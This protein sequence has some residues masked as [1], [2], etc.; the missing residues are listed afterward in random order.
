MA[1]RK[2]TNL[3][4]SIFQT[5]A[6]EKYLNAT[7]DQLISEPNNTQLNQFIG[8]KTGGSFQKNDSYVTESTSQRQNYQLEPSV[9]YKDSSGNVKDVHTVDD[10][11]NSL[12]YN[13]AST[14][15]QSLLFA[16]QYYNYEGW[17]DTDKL[18][19]Y[20]EYFWLPQGPDVV[21]VGGN[22]V[23]NKKTFTVNRTSLDSF[24]NYYTFDRNTDIN[25]VIYLARGGEYTFNVNQVSAQIGFDTVD[26]DSSGY[27]ANTET[28]VAEIP[29]Y[30]QTEIGTSGVSS[31]QSNIS[32]REV[33]GVVNNG[34]GT[35]SIIFRVPELSDIDFYQN[36]PIVEQNVNFATELSYT[37]IHNKLKSQIDSE[38]N[39]IDG[40]LNYVGKTLVFANSSADERNWEAGGIF[41]GNAGFDSEVFDPT[42]VLSFAERYSI[43]RIDVVDSGTDQLIQLTQIKNIPEF[44]RVSI[45]E[46]VTYARRQFYKNSQQYLELVPV[47]TST[48][49]TLYYQDGINPNMFGR[50]VL[51]DQGS[52]NIID[53][54]NDIIAQQDYTAPNGVVF[55]NGLK[56][57]FDSSV[58]P[59]E[60]Q[61]TVY[62]VEG[63]GKQGGICLV[64]ESK[65]IT[66]ESYS[67]DLSEP[68]DTVGFDSGNFDGTENSPTD[69]D[70]ILINR[71]SRDNNGW[72]RYNRWFHKKV[73]E[74]SATYNNF[75]LVIDQNARAKRP[76]L[77]FLP[78][79]QLFNFG[80][81]SK[82]PVSLFDTTQT[83]ALSN[84]AST[85]G[86]YSDNIQLASQMRIVFSAD[87]D[88]DVRR[89]VYRVDF[90]DQDSNESTGK[91]IDLVP[92]DTISEDDN[93]TVNFGFVNQGKTFYYKNSVWTEGQSKTKIMQEPLFDIF[94]GSH[95]SLSDTT[96][97]PSSDFAGSK[98]F[99]YKRNTVAAQDSVLG[100]GISYK[101]F[102]NIGDIVFENNFSTD[103]F[104]YTKTGATDPVNII[105]KSGHVHKH[106]YN[107]GTRSIH[108]GWRQ[109]KENSK[110][111]QVVTHIA[112]T[113]LYS[114]EIGVAPSL[115][116]FANI[117]VYVNNKFITS[118]LY[119]NTLINQK[120]YIV[121]VNPVKKDDNIVIKV[122]S[123]GQTSLGYYEVPINLENNANNEDFKDVT[124]GQIRNH[125]VE[126]IENIPNWSGNILGSNVSKD[127]DI[128]AYPGKILQHSAGNILSSYLLNN[129]ETNFFESLEYSKNEYTRFKN[130]FLDNVDKL[131]IDLQ[132]PI[133][134]V[135]KII[136]FMIGSKTNAF[137]FYYSDMLPWGDQKTTYNYVID[138][139]D[140]TF[141]EFG[142]QFDLTS[143]SQRGVLVYLT[144][145]NTTTQLLNGQ[146]Y[147]LDSQVA[148]I[149]LSTDLILNVNDTITIVEYTDTDGSF[150][151][152]TPTKLGLWPKY[153]PSIYLEDLVGYVD[154][155]TGPYKIYGTLDPDYAQLGKGSVGFVYPLYTDYNDAVTRDTQLGGEGKA[156]VHKFTGTNR[157]FYMPNSEAF[158]GAQDNTALNAYPGVR[159]VIRG[160]DGSKFVGEGD[161]R[162][163][164][165]L[166]LESR[167][168]NNIKTQYDSSLLDWST[169][170]TGFFRNTPT[171]R[172]V[173]LDI[174]RSSWGSWAE[175]NRVEQ[176][177]NTTFS[178]VNRF[179]WNHSQGA[180]KIE[181]QILPGGYRAI[182]NWLYDTDT[183]HL[184]PWEMLGLSEKPSWW[185]LRYGKPP[186]T[187]GNTVLWE[188]LRDGKLYT[189]GLGNTFTTIT[190][191]I[192]ADLME[193]I[194]VDSNGNLI[195]PSDF[196]GKDIFVSNANLDWKFGDWSPQETA[197]R[198]SSE[199]P[200]AVQLLGMLTAP[201]KYASLLWDTNLYEY[202]TDLQQI[203]Q[204]KRTYRPSLNAYNLH[205][206]QNNAGVVNRIEGYNQFI[207]NYL[208]YSNRSTVESQTRVQNLTLNLAYKVAGFTDKKFIK[209]AASNATPSTSNNNI[210]I[211]DEDINIAITKGTPLTKVFYSAVKIVKTENG[212]KLNG[213]DVKNP[214]FKIIPSV[215]ND[216]SKKF[217]IAS[218]NVFT[219]YNDYNRQIVSIPYGTV[220]STQQQVVDFLN[221]LQRYYNSQGIVFNTQE[222]GTPVDFLTGAKEFV[223]WAA[224]G[225][226]PGTVFS[227]S[228]G[229]QTLVVSRNQT[230]IDDLSNG[231]NLR[232][233]NGKPIRNEDYKVSRI[234]NTTTI[235]INTDNT[236]LASA[237]LDPI[238]YEHILVF[239]NTTIFNDLIYNPALGN[240]QERLKVIG[241]KTGNWNGTLHA[242]GFI[243][244]NDLF[245]IWQSNQN[246][247]RGDYVS[248]RN[249]LFVANQDHNGVEIFNY[250]FWDQLPNYKAGLL[251]NTA[252][253]SS[254]FENYFDI[255]KINLESNVDAAGKGII[256]FRKREWLENLGLDDVSQVKF[257]Q[258]MIRQKGTGQVIDKLI[259]ADLTNLNQEIS[260]YEEWGF[261]VGEYGSTDSNQVVEVTIDESNNKNNPVTLEFL[262]TSDSLQNPNN[263]KI[264]SS[265]LYRT[266]RG[267][268]KDIWKT[269][270][271]L[272]PVNDLNTV[273]YPRIDDVDHTIVDLD[274]D[275]EDF[276]ATV[277]SVMRGDKVWVARN[278]GTWDIFRV[279]ETLTNVIN[280]N[281]LT[282][283]F[284]ELTFDK[285]H[286]LVKDDVIIVKGN[287]IISGAYKVQEISASNTIIIKTDIPFIDGDLQDNPAPVYKFVSVRFTYLKDLSGYS[288]AF[289]F[290]INEFVWV[291][292]DNT[293]K[294][295][296]YQKKHV[297]DFADLKTSSVTDASAHLGN[298]VSISTTGNIAL[299]GAP[300]QNNGRVINYK[301]QNTKLTAAGVL[302]LTNS[303]IDGFGWAL[304]SGSDR[305]AIGAPNTN[306]NSGSVFVYT[307]N[308]DNDLQLAQVLCPN[309][310]ANR[311]Y[312]YSIA[313]S[314][315]QQYMV[316]GSPG[317]N[318]CYIY[319]LN[320][321]T[322]TTKTITG[323]GNT[324]YALGFTP[325]NAESILVQ[326]SG[327]VYIPNLDYTVT[328]SNI[329]FTSAVL[330][331]TDPIVTENTHY[332]QIATI[333]GSDTVAADRFGH[334]VDIDQNGRTII[335]GAPD[336]DVVDS[337]STLIANAGEVYIFSNTVEAFVANGTQTDFATTNPINTDPVIKIDIATSSDFA[338]AGQTVKFTTAPAKDSIVEVFTGTYKQTQ[339][340]DQNITGE[341]PTTGEQFGTSVS[342]DLDGIILAIGSPGEDET[343]PNTGS[344]FLYADSG[345]RVNIVQTRGTNNNYTSGDTYFVND[346]EITAS[347]SDTTLATFVADVN[348]ANI[349]GVSAQLDPTNSNRA[350][351]LG[352]NVRVRAGSGNTFSTGIGIQPYIKI[353]KINHPAGLE[354]ENF[355][356][357]V[358]F[359]KYIASDGTK[360]SNLV[361]SSSKNSTLIGVG[362]DIVADTTDPLY[363]TYK[364]TFDSDGTLFTDRIT[365]SGAA[366]TYQFVGSSNE[367]LT[368]LPQFIFEQK[369][370]NSKIN[371]LDE[372]GSSV[373][374]MN[375]TLLIGSKKD[376]E[377]KTNA[378][379]VYEFTSNGNLGWSKKRNETDKVDIKLFNNTMLYSKQSNEVLEF[380]DYID[381]YKLKVVGTAQQELNYLVDY[382]PAV[383]SVGSE[384]VNVNTNNPWNDEYVGKVWWDL[385]TALYLEYEQ[386]ELDYRTQNWGKLFPGATID[387]YEWIESSVPPSQYV[388]NGGEGTPKDINNFSVQTQY[389]TVNDSTT[390]KYYF[391]V[392]DK[393]TVPE[394]DF[395]RISTSA[396]ASLIQD[397]LSNGVKYLQFVD[398]NAVNI[399][400]IAN[401][402]NADNTVLSINYDRTSNDGVLHSQYELVSEGDASQ[403]LPDRI[404]N[405]LV[406]SISGQDSQGNTVPNPNLTPANKY[407]IEVRPRQTVYR[408]RFKALQVFVD[409]CNKIF[410]TFPVVRQANLS[411][412]LNTSES[413]P[414]S[415]SG[416]WDQK[417]LDNQE[418][419]FVNVAIINAGYKVL[420]ETD[421][422][423]NNRWSIYTLQTDKTWK[424]TRIQSYNTTESWDYVTWYSP[425][426]NDFTIPLYQ[427]NTESDLLTLVNATSGEIAKV[428]SNDDG[429]ISFYELQANNTW[430]EVIIE[431]GTIQFKTSLYLDYN[432]QSTSFPNFETRNLFA[433]IKNDIFINQ[434]SI[435]MNQLFFRLIEYALD[436]YGNAHPDWLFKSSFIRVTHK[437][438]DLSQ[439][440]TFRNDNSEFVENFI[441]EVKPYKTKIRDY[442]TRYEGNDNF[443]GDVSD[444]DV[445]S[446]YDTNKGYFRK[447]SGDF[448][449]DA[450]LQ[451]Q[452][453]NNPWYSNYSYSIASI[454]IYNS[455]TGYLQDP[456]ITI[457]APDLSAGVQATAT[458]TTNGNSIILVTVTNKGSGYTRTP[459]LTLSDASGTGLKLV[460]RLENTTSRSFDVTL[461][462]DRFTY[463]TSVK[464]WTAN[465]SYNYLDL[466]AYKNT[467]TLEQELY[468][469]VVEAGFTSGSTFSSESAN[470]TEVLKVYADEL[471]TNNLDRIAGY[472]SP[473]AGMLGDD[474]KLLQSG[475]E[476]GSNRVSGPGFDN[477][478]GFDSSRF[479]FT[480]FDAFEIDTDGIE[481]LSGNLLDT[482]VK[483]EFSDSSLGQRP[484]DINIDG[485]EFVD[486]YNSHAPEEFI[487][488]MVYDTLD[489]EVYTDPSDDFERDGNSFRV[490]HRA[491]F[492][493][494][495]KKTFT[496]RSESRNDDVD[497]VFAWVNQTRQHDFTVDFQ[498]GTITFATAPA[499]AKSVYIYGYS[500]TGEQL[501]HEQTFVGDGTTNSI[502]LGV[503]TAQVQQILVVKN[504]NKLVKDTDFTT[505]TEN[506]RTVVTFTDI[507]LLNDN[508]HIVTSSQNSSRDAF[509]L[510]HV[511]EITLTSG[512]TTYNLDK[513]VE[514]IQPLEGAVVA[515][516]G[517]H[518]LRPSN[519]K[520]YT[521]DGSTI[522]YSIPTTAGEGAVA[523]GDIRVS[524]VSRADQ[525]TLSPGSNK[526][527]NID[528][529]IGANDG[530]SARTITFFDPPAKN[531]LIII[532]V[533]TGAEYLIDSNTVTLTSGVTF[534]TGDKLYITSFSNHD[535][536]IV[537]TKVFLGLGNLMTTTKE[538]F[539]T[540]GFDS[541]GYDA[542]IV[543][544]VAVAKYQLDRVTTKAGYLWV[545]LDGNRL[546]PG[547]YSI[548]SSNRLDLQ[549]RTID[550]NSE[551]I[552]TSF[553]ENVIQPTLGF[554]IFKDMLGQYNYFRICDD[555]ATVLAQDLNPTDTKIY[556]KDVTKLSNVSPSSKNPGVIF[557]GNERITYWEVDTTNNYVTNIRRSTRGTRYS[558]IHRA[559]VNVIDASEDN[560][561]PANDTHTKTWYTA[562][563]SSAANGL[564]IQASTTINSKFLKACT[565][566]VQNYIKEL[567]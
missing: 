196:V 490:V 450:E 25:P 294:W 182:Y 511:Q 415:T 275:L 244:S 103:T 59:A 189:D 145:S 471:L 143:V 105:L 187:S 56:I 506:G 222:D 249:D 384:V 477:A 414:T 332:T 45:Q 142:T 284:V 385:S 517:S 449:E 69:P 76:I 550:E 108:N 350:Q 468:Q 148:G 287:S 371:T 435:Y 368:N 44:N 358:A 352:T 123:T 522:T 526:I 206:V 48:L 436:E 35:G 231:I 299:A 233:Y 362:F 247:K 306:S 322:S 15:D 355:G 79:I 453:Y 328:G 463:K 432:S 180:D 92:V 514:F 86:Y 326:T 156:H 351:I 167:I 318:I 178:T 47:L 344:V 527:E 317:A 272:T 157:I 500:V 469:V 165:L 429:N 507:P 302:S 97:Y 301:L 345:Q 337:T 433:G 43:F 51:V 255:D 308:T 349:A 401:D 273:G 40:T 209:I 443:E 305:H 557:V 533:R 184:T 101:N 316:V 98:L 175:K 172:V 70:Y 334:S 319:K 545:T 309:T 333:T 411:N 29:F 73:I 431:R 77:E 483:S 258:G 381:P 353:Q 494:G 491:Y 20:G 292:N 416:S 407:G 367:S 546:H 503:T 365:Q 85:T 277:D 366:Y 125:F 276:G 515:E 114:F 270:T 171:D 293:G 28:G 269:R 291:D 495:K 199:Y 340:I 372:F 388:D 386:G 484:E 562:G 544:G 474:F 342:T 192:R 104:Q 430:K 447:P 152:P 82:E 61:D 462:F 383:Y 549:G 378:G 158:H 120:N 186:Y 380:L 11:L 210:F 420:V 140:E 364:T 554:R 185:D 564:G 31:Q 398:S 467:V 42:T 267:F 537:Q 542:T 360:N 373:A 473:T 250:E 181:N 419:G 348:L 532:S 444:F 502:A 84:V 75:T 81:S 7:L 66:P 115:S 286:A 146:D 207:A 530:S 265:D 88:P 412:Y 221:A 424:Q 296:A 214:S 239:N 17:V 458:A 78:N 516:L 55:E 133:E 64:P 410:L 136:E 448:A 480:G 89:T 489:M 488:G 382:D 256:G 119:T 303:A 173:E 153:K 531:D 423:N 33:Q 1:L 126:S 166:E 176:T 314:N 310:G 19:N 246:Y 236:Q 117:K 149:N 438:R 307:S 464:D 219:L 357:T 139:P 131:D 53:V 121:F 177:T 418:L 18:V 528:Y 482:I 341:S 404:Y 201:A 456:V 237:V 218:D 492:G 376:D 204:T 229:Y 224:Q 563:T 95:K 264:T 251:K 519:S 21:N 455:G 116:A 370:T 402:L 524:V 161:L 395:R 220:L 111:F 200:F 62:Y 513:T 106:D 9:I 446:F 487:P 553:S 391:W 195:P 347:V 128:A 99:S 315:D 46:G 241:Q 454:E 497:K 36:M 132:K 263:V 80:I 336:A 257:Y 169:V 94:D 49:D 403:I 225:W 321:I 413:I 243:I 540:V 253:R 160:H 329:T 288:P 54:D 41:D 90:I 5:K 235:T 129:K 91:I 72:S 295:A 60:Y 361:V 442:T 112:N 346:R 359:N 268:T 27:D 426:F 445:H 154:E 63:V 510:P 137:P 479:D 417:V 535:P 327:Q 547:E 441:N 428:L 234:D 466:V 4:P 213:Y 313:I 290:N 193:L 440:P 555:N 130:R 421:S 261:R 278:K 499:V 422:N 567:E 505:S 151:P 409:F 541:T 312:G 425:G 228:P 262:D 170:L 203:V 529:T 110:Q 87:L 216:N 34:A 356:Q 525:S 534:N 465:T 551:I 109:I 12:R 159:T 215:Q 343:R 323:N 390:T 338:I 460:P 13:N 52:Q 23:D 375:K 57:E 523:D 232:D 32:T 122:Y 552:V 538:G 560:R 437:L 481:V 325:V 498:A 452:G 164:L 508:L 320:T 393:T 134:S 475:L 26:Y 566:V 93:I 397:P 74:N 520:L 501:T 124:L 71:A 504:G 459:T 223:F 543:T 324:T 102:N 230:T 377:Y 289:G 248:F 279:D 556:V 162:D 282:T 39:G 518:R 392:K 427:V 190:T 300:D 281:N 493:N 439:Y 400:N 389:D 67:N 135:D 512:V 536:L 50:I 150:I 485:G 509:T 6:N 197:W 363:K 83:D 558:S 194:P 147:T 476:Y 22:V 399:V 198:H 304:A 113:E 457:S 58:L 14:L 202:N 285:S 37:Q 138:N 191:R 434:N 24:D 280:V 240:R 65:L 163:N 118:D 107:T 486:V 561:M 10:T 548:D 271:S 339:K 242:P 394:V 2:S 245:N 405:K 217:S 3:L 559:G 470:G 211:P 16:Q 259:N 252:H 539:D 208:I 38:Y 188:D 354:N 330:S 387:C 266:P 461:K 30:I 379:S 297:W 212:F 472:Y 283:D 141:F 496:F 127:I 274:L 226:G 369:I 8:R 155:N 238:Q 205:T 565:A 406:D 179:T 451:S 100:F 478:P 260:F 311:E 254:D 227:I 183:P 168:Y 96:V 298:S 521:S 396:I 331:G 335:V 374:Y 174:L 68:F 144:S 408:N